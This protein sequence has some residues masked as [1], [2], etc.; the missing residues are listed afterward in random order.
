MLEPWPGETEESVLCASSSSS[1]FQ[2]S[3]RA[4]SFPSLSLFK[5]C[6]IFTWFKN[7]NL[8]KACMLSLLT[9][10]LPI[11]P[12][13]STLCPKR[14][15]PAF[16]YAYTV[17]YKHRVLFVLTLTLTPMLFLPKSTHCLLS[18]SPFFLS[19]IN[20][21]WRIFP[22]HCRESCLLLRAFP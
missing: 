17:K 21:S 18:S 2:G 10:Y 6:V 22:P 13:Y 1:I 7:Q 15:L 14:I 3:A 9:F 19:F 11:F 12:S 5:F 8:S 20:M 4:F 16:L